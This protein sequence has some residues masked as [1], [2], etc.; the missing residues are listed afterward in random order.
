MTP[1]SRVVKSTS[2]WILSLKGVL[3]DMHQYHCDDSD[4]LRGT[5]CLMEETKP[6]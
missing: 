5:A 4:H 6:G 2:K 1:D 3:A